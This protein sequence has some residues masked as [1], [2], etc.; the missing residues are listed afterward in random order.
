MNESRKSPSHGNRNTKRVAHERKSDSLALRDA[1]HK[2]VSIRT[3]IVLL[4]GHRMDIY[5]VFKLDDT[6][7]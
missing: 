7:Y 3:T 6:S 1:M 5:I 2:L 4:A